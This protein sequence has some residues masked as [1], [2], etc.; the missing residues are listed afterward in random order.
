MKYSNYLL[1]LTLVFFWACEDNTELID[2]LTNDNSKFQ[3]EITDLTV[4]VTDL[5]N[6]LNELE[7]E[8]NKLKKDIE[9]LQEDQNNVIEERNKLKKEI[10]ELDSEIIDVKELIVAYA[11]LVQAD[12][13]ESVWAAVPI[14]MEA[15][16]NEKASIRA[17]AAGALGFIG[18]GLMGGGNGFLGEEFIDVTPA[19]VQAVPALIEALKDRDE[20]VRLNSTIALEQIGLTGAHSLKSAVPVLIKLFQDQDENKKTRA[21]AAVTLG[22]TGVEDAESLLIQS[23]QNQDSEGFI[24]AS[25]ARGLGFVGGGFFGFPGFREVGNIVPVLIE[26]LRDKDSEVR[27]NSA[28]SLGMIA[29]MDPSEVDNIV[30]ALIEALEDGNGKVRFNAMEALWMIGTPEAIEA[31][32]QVEF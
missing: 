2:K 12:A 15:L 27:A 32:A 17:N 25:A 1:I 9:I 16:E 3:T 23:L 28:I 8:R 5:K 20:T 13:P 7:T 11:S 30:F 19:V 29:M 18:G 24:R 14:L 4:V 31:A 6:N 26:S 21:H 22:L 10:V